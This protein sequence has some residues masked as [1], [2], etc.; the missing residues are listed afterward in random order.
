[1]E[2]T[3]D[4]HSLL[5]SPSD[6]LSL[7]GWQ[8]TPHPADNAC[9]GQ[10]MSQVLTQIFTLFLPSFSSKIKPP[11]WKYMLK[12]LLMSTLD[13]V[14]F[15][16]RNTSHWAFCDLFCCWNLS[17]CWGSTSH[18]AGFHSSAHLLT[19]TPPPPLT[20]SQGIPHL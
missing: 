16:P 19:P 9:P 15:F 13:P 1:M 6:T 12:I 14:I 18:W 5:P 7:K 4:T 10:T 20:N 11:I 8:E 2:F 3:Q 17:S